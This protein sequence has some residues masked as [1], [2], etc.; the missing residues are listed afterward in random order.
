[1]VD[2]I[3]QC[4]VKPVEP[5]TNSAT[6]EYNVQLVLSNGQSVHGVKKMMHFRVLNHA[7]N[8]LGNTTSGIGAFYKSSPD[9]V[10]EIP[11]WADNVKISQS[12]VKPKMR[13][14]AAILSTFLNYATGMESSACSFTCVTLLFV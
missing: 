3:N 1:M 7:L 12:I 11:E 13:E 5:I 6:Q 8:A 9:I 4:Q 10:P 14:R 2:R